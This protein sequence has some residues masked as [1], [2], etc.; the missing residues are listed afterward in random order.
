MKKILILF[1]ITLN[2]LVSGVNYYISSSGGNDAANGT[3]ESTPWKTIARLNSVFSS[4][5]PG[6]K[7]LFKRGDTFYGQLKISRSGLPGNPITISAYGTG[8]KPII[9]G[10]TTIFGWTDEGN[11]IFSRTVTCK[12][13]PEMMII[14][15]IQHA[16]GRYPNFTWLTID[17]HSGD[18]SITDSELNANIINWKGAEIV[19]RKGCH[20]VIDRYKITDHIDQ[21]LYYSG[22][23]KYPPVNGWGYFIQNDKKTLDL[24]GE[25][26]YD[27]STS[28][29]YLFFGTNNPNDYK[30]EIS[31]IDDLVTFS[32]NIDYITLDNIMFIGANKNAV[33]C[34]LND[35]IF[36][37]NCDFDFSGSS[38]VR[39]YNTMRLDVS[40]STINHSND[41]GIFTN[42]FSNH[43]TRVT[44]TIIQNSGLIP[45]LGVSYDGI[46]LGQGDS[47]LIENNQIYNS[48]YNGINF[49]G[50]GSIIRNNFV[51][52]FCALK[53]DGGG[54]YYGGQDL[55]K[56][57]LITDNIVL[58]ALGAPG[59]A[60]SGT[61]SMAAGIY[62]DYKT[63]GGAKIINNTVAFSNWNGIYLH[64][65]ENVEIINNTVY[66]IANCFKSQEY[67]GISSP[68]RNISMNGNVF[69]ARNIKQVPLRLNSSYNDFDQFGTFDNNF[70]A[71]PLDKDRPILPSIN[72]SGTPKTL[73][74]WQRLYGHDLNSK[75]SPIIL[76]DTADIDFY[77]N[78]TKTDK[79]I[80]LNEPMIDVRGTKYVNSVTLA[81]FTSIILMVDPNPAES[82]IPVYVSSEIQNLTPAALE[83]TYHVKL[84]NSVPPPSAF[85]VAVNGAD[86]SVT[87]VAV[88]D[89]KVILNLSSPVA[90]GDVVTVSYNKPPAVPFL[91][92]LTGGA[93]VTITNQ[94]VTNNLFNPNAPN[95]PP[96]L[97]INNEA[98]YFSG[99]VGEIDASGSY[100][101]N[102]D[103]LNFEWI[104]PDDIP[105]SSTDSSKIRFL[106]PVL[107]ESQILDFTLNVND[108]KVIQSEN[109][110]FSVLPYK[111][112]FPIS[113]TTI[114]EASEYSEPDYPAN[115]ADGDLDTK[116]SVN[117]DNQW[118]LFTLTY[119]FK[120]S[121]IQLGFISDQKYE[122]YFDIYA[123]KDNLNW[124]PAII[125]KA[126]CSFSGNLQFFDFPAEKTLTA[127]SY[128]KL[129]GHGSALDSWNNYS[130]MKVFGNIVDPSDITENISIFPNPTRDQLN[131]LILEPFAESLLLKIFD[132]NGALCFEHQL[133]PNVHNAQIPINLGAGVYLVQVLLGS[134]IMFAQTLLIV[135]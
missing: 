97:I 109:I 56:N 48:G 11:G 4:I 66:D 126:S 119:P 112:G 50:T 44:G 98:T 36:I 17:S 94:P 8:D 86:R 129:I 108:G 90:Y 115:I 43:K 61:I 124:E 32:A 71:R 76:T 125:K 81:P 60:P 75:I 7:I 84:A 70:Y 45:G 40:N 9:T 116:W 127:Y 83:M 78:E 24:F 135:K 106:S 87:S 65:C 25:W 92:S 85:K 28:T 130:E 103:K 82:V 93:A 31:T 80:T 113:K 59:G 47:M 23:G 104:V 128:V 34:Y 95:D 20:F 62:L 100:D 102:G 15:G 22:N 52:N 57:L 110:Q 134:V 54:I 42:G 69:F 13:A 19:Q 132:S 72:W 37:E 133:N 114:I 46:S 35:Y 107:N 55:Y 67:V 39:G 89:Y 49:K 120:V 21:T 88:S 58:N 51:F 68:T 73:E 38:A 77:Y 105:V 2:S 123:S 33:Y 63:T 74:E 14:N 99:F 131:V 111:P 117:G 121:H 12:S 26:F 18:I 1:F 79:I 10:F 5:K 16:M 41:V 6:D 29:F 27:V 3:S 30:V 122:S 118:L 91:Q 64:G 53:D 96:V 101:P